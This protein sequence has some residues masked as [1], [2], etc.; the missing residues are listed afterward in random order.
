MDKTE[1]LKFINSLSE[2][3]RNDITEKILSGKIP[4][5]WNEMELLQYLRDLTMVNSFFLDKKRKK[6]YENTLIVNGL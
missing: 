5:S 6:N 4:E 1:Q 2:N 3:L